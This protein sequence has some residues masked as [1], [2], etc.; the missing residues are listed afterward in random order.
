MPRFN[1]YKL[2]ILKVHSTCCDLHLFTGHTFG[3][4]TFYLISRTHSGTFHILHF[5][6]LAHSHIYGDQWRAWGKMGPP[7]AAKWLLQ[8]IDYGY[9]AQVSTWG[10]IMSQHNCLQMPNMDSPPLVE[11][12]LLLDKKSLYNKTETLAPFAFRDREV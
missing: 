5:G 10:A 9:W 6:V 8:I 12:T 2:A 3:A 1:H 7:Q 11:W 4:N